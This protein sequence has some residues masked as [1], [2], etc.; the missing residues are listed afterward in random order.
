MKRLS[1]LLLS[2]LLIPSLALAAHEKDHDGPPPA[3]PAGEDAKAKID[4]DGNGTVSKAEFMAYQEKR[5]NEADANHDGSI[6][7]E[8][9]KASMQKWK[10]KRDEM[11]AKMKDENA[12]GMEKGEATP[13][14]E[15]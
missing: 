9:H 13:K 5:F 15:E 14:G 10:A 2:A 1:L 3:P 4:T 7:D 12:P 11:R 6:T 8:E